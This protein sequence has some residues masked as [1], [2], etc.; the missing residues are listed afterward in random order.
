MSGGVILTTINVNLLVALVPKV[1][2]MNS[3]SMDVL[4]LK[5]YM[6]TYITE[7]TINAWPA[8]SSYIFHYLELLTL[9]DISHFTFPVTHEAPGRRSKW[10]HSAR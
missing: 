8:I 10:L 3:D 1:L 9:Y 4:F 5:E 6:L 7:S 2:C